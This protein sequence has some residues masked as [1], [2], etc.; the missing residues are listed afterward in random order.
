MKSILE[1]HHFIIK[2]MKQF[3]ECTIVQLEQGNKASNNFLSFLPESDLMTA[4]V[5]TL[6]Y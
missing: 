6:V 5:H 3:M 1:L 2:F 4:V